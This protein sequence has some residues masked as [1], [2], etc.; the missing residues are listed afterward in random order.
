MTSKPRILI[1]ENSVDVTG[2]LKSISA[3]VNELANEFDFFYIIPSGSRAAGWIAENVRA[4]TYE[5]PMIQISRSWKSIVL[6]LPFLIVN[7]IRV[8]KL[9]HRER[10]HIVHSNDLYNLIPPFLKYFGV[11]FGYVCHVRFL[12]GGFPPI[13]FNFWIKRQLAAA[14]ALFAVSSFLRTQ[15]PDNPKILVLY[16]RI[17]HER[18]PFPPNVPQRKRLLYLSNIIPGKGHETALHVIHRVLEKFPGW[19][20]RFVGGDMGLEKNMR[21]RE[22]LQRLSSA[23]D[24]MVEWSGLTAD[25]ET[26]YRNSDI[27]L[28]FSSSESFSMTCLEAQY[29]GRAVIASRS[30]GPEEIIEDGVTG[31][32]VPGNDFDRAAEAVRKL[33][34][35]KNLR[36]RMGIAGAERTR[37]KFSRAATTSVLERTYRA[38]YRH[39]Q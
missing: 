33:I 10:I 20:I 28:N 12:P 34:E 19:K 38:L 11:K 3:M 29:Y 7:S 14:S 8:R 21:Y 26:E 39:S 32:L 1:I 35:D 23:F 25:V 18:D 2:A 30:G 13:L 4:K 27:V 22:S 36:D 24:H 16:D 37:Q 9:I 17:L 6:F 31:I 15:L 5:L